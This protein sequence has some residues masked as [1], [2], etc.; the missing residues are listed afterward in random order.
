MIS[1]KHYI[2][3]IH[4]QVVAVRDSA[5]KV[6]GTKSI[7]RSETNLSFRRRP[8]GLCSLRHTLFFFYLTDI[9]TFVM[10]V[11][12]PLRSKIFIISFETLAIVIM[13][14]IFMSLKLI[15]V[16]E[17]KNSLLCK[18]KLCSQLYDLYLAMRKFTYPAWRFD[19]F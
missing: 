8:Q 2:K 6:T 18:I 16:S 7:P 11:K 5:R 14:C 1:P 12:G 10:H 15:A 19:D 4:E 17:K 9:I 13:K 3:A